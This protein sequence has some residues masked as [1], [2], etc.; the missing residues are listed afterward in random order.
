M[1]KWI[2]ASF[3]TTEEDYVHFKLALAKME[4][5]KREIWLVRILGAVF[6]AAGILGT[7]VLTGGFYLKM[8]SV[9]LIF[10]GIIMAL[11]CNILL[12]SVVRHG[13]ANYYEA[14]REKMIAATVSFKKTAFS[15]VTD[16]YQLEIPY[17]MLYRVYEDKNVFLLCTGMEEV[18]FLA[19]RT[20][21]AEEIETVRTRLQKVIGEKYQRIK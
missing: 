21:T 2:V 3:L 18:R 13:A 9:C 7:W 11:Y 1:D 8:V 19:K 4:L 20:L 5:K 10:V 12:P 16:R 14:Y 15:Y 17:D 6:L